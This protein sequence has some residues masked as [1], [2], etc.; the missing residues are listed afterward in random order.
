MH[1]HKSKQKLWHDVMYF[2]W[3]HSTIVHD[4]FNNTRFKWKYHK[5]NIYMRAKKIDGK[6]LRLKFLDSYKCFAFMDM[7]SHLILCVIKLVGYICIL[8]YV[9]YLFAKCGFI[10]LV[11][12]RTALLLSALLV[13]T[14]YG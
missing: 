8:V 2:P 11:Y 9:E 4:G 6:T 3:F 13:L 5:L 7:H 14:M 12:F 10:S 1:F